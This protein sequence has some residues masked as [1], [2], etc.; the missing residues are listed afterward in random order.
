VQCHF[1]A[2]AL[3]Q[4]KSRRP[5]L[6]M[7]AADVSKMPFADGTFDVMTSLGLVEH[8]QDGPDSALR[9]HRR[10]PRGGGMLILTAPRISPLKALLDLRL[11]A[12][13]VSYTS[14][15][16]RRIQR[17]HEM[18]AKREQDVMPTFYQYEFRD[19]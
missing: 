15:M 13:Q 16:G 18:A 12:R 2:G 1:P 19:F 17:V 10:V 11:V 4:A 3:A 14:A 6:P 9:E 5:H 8:F 7:I